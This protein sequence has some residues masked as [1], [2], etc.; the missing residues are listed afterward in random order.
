MTSR[1]RGRGQGF[2]D[3]GTKVLALKIGTMGEGMSKIG[4]YC[5]TSLMGDL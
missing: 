2:C 1:F 5:V 4:Q 3:D